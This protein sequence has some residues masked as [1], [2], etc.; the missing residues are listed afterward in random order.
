[1]SNF[2]A[3]PFFFLITKEINKG[4]KGWK[5]FLHQLPGGKEIRDEEEK[6]NHLR[7]KGEGFHHGHH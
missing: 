2:E 1:M 4:G 7:G 3:V 6:W 5:D